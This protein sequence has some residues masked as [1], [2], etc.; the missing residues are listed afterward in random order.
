MTGEAV[1]GKRSLDSADAAFVDVVTDLL[2]RGHGV[3]FRA[4]GGSMYPAICDGEAVTVMP[5]APGAIRRGDV[6]LYRCGRAVIAHRVRRVVPGANGALAFVTAGDTSAAPDAP[7]DASAVLGRVVTV[8][9]DGRTVPLIGLRS[10]LAGRFMGRI[11]RL[12]MRVRG[13]LAVAGQPSGG[14][15]EPPVQVLSEATSGSAR[16]ADTGTPLRTHA[17]ARIAGWRI[18]FGKFLIRLARFLESLPPAVMRPDE[19]IEYGRRHY[20]R[21]ST[22]ELWV[23]DTVVDRGLN[24]EESATLTEV[25]RRDGRALVLGL[26]GGREAIA[27][28]KMGFAVTGVD[29]IPE[30]MTRAQENA[31]RRG[32]TITGLVQDMCDL[33]VP[34]EAFSLVWLS[35]GMYS[36]LPTRSRRIEL[37][38]QV[39]RVLEPGGWFVCGFSWDPAHAPNPTGVALRRALAV[40][41]LGNRSY[42]PGDVLW[43]GVEFMHVFCAESDLRAEFD[44]SGLELVRLSLPPAGWGLAVLRQPD[45][46][47]RG[48]PDAVAGS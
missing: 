34:A 23:G 24:T 10:R 35:A 15:S 32:V 46:G 7:G 31:A 30:M 37:A 8:E 43:G 19:L 33:D 4:K 16:G 48:E 42:E 25:P 45:G 39:R 1:A 21:A 5:A 6:I 29:Y 17:R 44:L 47:L 20:G 36:C 22:V 12:A 38:R 11:L 2:R 9:R 3:R 14:V 18:S 26:G 27:L 40:V 28:A 13:G 41:T